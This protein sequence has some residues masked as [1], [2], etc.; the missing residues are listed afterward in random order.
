MQAFLYGIYLQWKLDLRNRDILIVYYVVPL[1]FFAFMGGIFTT[2]NPQAYETIIASMAIF[3]ITMGAYLG[4]PVPLVQM[5]GSEMKK[6]YKVGGI[7]LWTAAFNNYISACI[8]L[9][10]MS[11]IIVFIAPLVFNATIPDNLGLFLFSMFIFIM[12]C[13]AVGTVL[14]LLVKSATKLTMISQVLFLPSIMLSGIMFPSDLLPDVMSTAG[15]LFP[16]AWGYEIMQQ[17]QFDIMSYL[18]LCIIFIVAVILCIILLQR[19]Q[20]DR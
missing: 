16:A 10:I 4:T 8:H 12:T 2:I 20:K 14:G 19:V 6:S 13:T 7:P 5:Y 18:P 15:K 9:F 11:L 1:V 17:T 3:G